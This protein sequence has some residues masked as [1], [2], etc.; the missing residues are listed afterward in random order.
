MDDAGDIREEQGEGTQAFSRFRETGDTPT[1]Q[2]VQDLD[3]DRF[4]ESESG[5][6]S[7]TSITPI[8]VPMTPPVPLPMGGK[9]IGDAQKRSLTSSSSS[10]VEV[11]TS[12]LKSTCSSPSSGDEASASA[13]TEPGGKAAS[14]SASDHGSVG[15]L[16]YPMLER[17]PTAG[18]R[19][20]SATSPHS[21]S[22][23]QAQAQAE[24][25]VTGGG[26]SAEITQQDELAMQMTVKNLDTGELLV[27][28]GPG[29]GGSCSDAHVCRAVGEMAAG[30]AS[31][32]ASML[33]TAGDSAER[34]STPSG[35]SSL[36]MGTKVAAWL[37]G[38][39]R[40]REASKNAQ[41]ECKPP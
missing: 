26:D 24:T 37:F 16:A 23:A 5:L 10:E 41:A 30:R 20:C 7:P 18:H 35:R 25:R 13:A 31:D 2:P 27:L 11:H 4:S 19:L 39:G 14:T 34:S 17:Y 6:F 22:Q 28:D 38:D 21:H 32:G 1:L 33:A 8:A 12:P 9:R 15:S 40:I 3:C 29:V 36:D